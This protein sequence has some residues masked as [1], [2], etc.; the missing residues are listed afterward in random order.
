MVG[1]RR[2]AD[3]DIGDSELRAGR[4]SEQQGGIEPFPIRAMK[5]GAFTGT[6]AAARR[7][8]RVFPE[9][10]ARAV[11]GIQEAG[12]MYEPHLQKASEEKPVGGV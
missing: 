3:R 6:R 10:S 9:A 12:N 4:R 2:G 7:F 1:A 8:L 11:A 5:H